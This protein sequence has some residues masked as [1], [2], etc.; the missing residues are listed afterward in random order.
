LPLFFVVW[1]IALDIY[2]QVLSGYAKATLRGIDALLED[3]L[4]TTHLKDKEI[5]AKIIAENG[6]IPNPLKLMEKRPGTVERFLAYSKQ[7]LE[8][9]SLSKREKALISIAATVALKASHCIHSKVEDAKKAA[10]SEDE[11]IQTMLIVG[12][13]TGNTM[14]HT[15]YEALSGQS[16]SE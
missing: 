11:I 2:R 14:M 10:V 1:P 16:G 9:G 3:T 6:W 15:A 13:I 12:L 5:L 8:N 7:I 4:E